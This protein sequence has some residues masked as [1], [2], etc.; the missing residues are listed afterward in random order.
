MERRRRKATRGHQQP[1]LGFL[2]RCPPRGQSQ[3]QRQFVT[4]PTRSKL[5]RSRSWHRPLL[6]LGTGFLWPQEQTTT[7][8]RLRTAALYP[9][10]DLEARASESRCHGPPGG[11]W[12]SGAG[13]RVPPPLP[14]SAVTVP[15]PP[16]TR[17]HGVASE[18]QR[19]RNT[20]SSSSP[21]QRA[22]AGSGD[23]FPGTGD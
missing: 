17:T 2:C 19:I 13:G 6:G 4:Q 23:I 20:P 12:P 21:L 22:F 7:N 5:R 18:A 11:P 3:P 1:S 14:P 9:V 8:W 15:L 16:F 10:T